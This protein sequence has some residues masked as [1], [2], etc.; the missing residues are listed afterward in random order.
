PLTADL[1]T[2]VCVVGAGIAGLSVAY[3]LARA[4]RRVT[5]VESGPGI[6][7]GET[8]RSTAHLANAVDDRFTVLEKMFGYDGAR[9][10]ASSHGAAIDTIAG[11]VADEG[12][13][14]DFERLDGYLFNPPQGGIDLV[15]ELEASRRAG[16]DCEMA[17]R[18]PIAGFDTGPAIRYRHQGRMDPLAYVRGL[19]RA[20][21]ARGGRIFTGTH[22]T[23]VEGGHPARVSTA[24][25]F[26][27]LCDAVVVATNVPVNDRIALHGKMAPYR[28]YVVAATVSPEAAADA[29][30]WDSAAPY[31]YVRFGRAG[32]GS[33]ML[34]VGGEDHR[35]G[36]PAHGDERWG[37]LEAWA[38]QRFPSFG[39]V[40]WRW[41][42]QIMEPADHVAFIGRNPMDEENVFVV[43]G[44]SG[45]GITHGTIAGLLLSDLVLGRD[46][47]WAELYD[48]SRVTLKAATGY[49]DTNLHVAEH[50]ADWLTG[51]D[52][53]DVRDVAPGSGAVIRSGLSKMAVYRDD[54]GTVHKRSAVCTHLKCIVAWNDAEKSWD[55]A[56][57][58]SRFDRFG[59][60][61]NGPANEPLS[62]IEE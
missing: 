55:C 20:V 46:N 41:S 23:S 4:G 34:V 14:C 1:R 32:D 15:G 39:A 57:H 38:R 54:G 44:D 9:L 30:Y 6:G 40:R 59:R 60:V 47:P 5:V 36:H 18:A 11:I 43:S 8:G 56:C 33:T 51:G 17:V 61:V 27:V 42:G 53:D 7:L 35:V 19:A 45:N 10:V 24:Q 31:H 2:D 49:A 37:R 62:P 26:H 48:P 3:L 50:Y 28:T 21:T 29:L 58:G 16:L 25:G 13:H 52:V 22:V 12:I